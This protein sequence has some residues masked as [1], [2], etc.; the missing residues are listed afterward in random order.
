MGYP[1]LIELTVRVT[2]EIDSHIGPC[3]VTVFA[4][5]SEPGYFEIESISNEH[6]G[7]RSPDS[8]SDGLYREIADEVAAELGARAEA[9]A[10]AREDR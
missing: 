7:V 10:E 9:Q 4:D 3:R 1:R 8:I 6:G 5:P 2:C